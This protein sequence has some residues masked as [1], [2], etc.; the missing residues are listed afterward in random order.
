MAMNDFVVFILTHNRPNNVI[1]Y[2][3]LRRSGYTGRIIL[4]IDNQDQCADQYIKK[5]GDQ[6]YIFDKN[7]IAKTFDEGDNFNDRRAVIYAR[8]ACFDVANKLGIRFFIQLDD[9]YTCFYYRFNKNGFYNQ[10]PI[11]RFLDDVFNAI[12]EYYRDTPFYTIAI[13]QGGDYIGG[14]PGTSSE[15]IRTK[16]KAMNSFFCDTQ[17]KF[18]FVGRINEDVNT[19]TCEQRRGIYMLTIFGVSL[20]QKSTQSS[21]GGMTE[22]YIDSGTYIKSFY[23]V[24]YAPSC[25]KISYIAGYKNSISHPRIHHQ[26]DWKLTAPYIINECYKKIAPLSAEH[27]THDR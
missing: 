20:N 24:M 19:Y 25:V 8:N 17:K 3:S 13:G 27:E 1:T 14:G 5:Y 7:E 15:S 6:V 16:R 9:D 4:L 12:F 2:N 22:L 21:D 11:S 23:T 18:K 26:V 10:R